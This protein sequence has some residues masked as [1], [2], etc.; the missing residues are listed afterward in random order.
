[1]IWGTFSVFL[2]IKDP[3]NCKNV[4]ITILSANVSRL[5]MPMFWNE[6][7]TPLWYGTAFLLHAIKKWWGNQFFDSPLDVHSAVNYLWSLK[8]FSRSFC[9]KQQPT[10]IILNK[11]SYTLMAVAAL[12]D[13]DQHIRSSLGL[14]ILPKDNSTCRPGEWSQQ[15]PSDN[16]TLALP[17]S[18]SR[19]F[20]P[21]PVFSHNRS[22]LALFWPVGSSE[23][24]TSLHL[25]RNAKETQQ[26]HYKCADLEV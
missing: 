17:L 24:N 10:Y 2:H 9:P 16:K 11:Y 3:T 15:Q 25:C 8:A 23:G 18:H 4:L 26:T 14:S 20:W 5:K 19:S 13:A 7:G 21:P 12:Q 6:T 1:M 22:Q